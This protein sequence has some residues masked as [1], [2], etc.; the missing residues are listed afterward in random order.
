MLQWQED[1][2]PTK[3]PSF[4]LHCCIACPVLQEMLATYNTR[5]AAKLGFKSP[6]QALNKEL[7]ILMLKSQVR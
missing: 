7:L 4:L 6:D 2:S 3:V 1:A 5:M